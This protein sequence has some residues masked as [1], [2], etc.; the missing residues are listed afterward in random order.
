MKAMSI[1]VKTRVVALLYGLASCA[2]LAQQTP[3]QT[4]PSNTIRQ[5]AS[6]NHGRKTNRTLSPDDGLAV[7]SA[8]LDSKV[9]VFPE[10]D[11]S[12]LV[13]AIYERAGFP[14]DYVS[15]YDLY[16]GVEGF[17]RVW[18]PQP[19]DLVVW[20]GHVGIVVR[21][22]RHVFYSFLRSGPSTD[23][24]ESPYWMSRGRPRFY[25]YIKNVSCAGCAS[26]STT[27]PRIREEK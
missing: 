19:G 27:F 26:V 22:S 5:G 25:R 23:D 12:H 1:Q 7:I 11:C 24:Y 17:Q 3:G 18:Y 20:Q 16:A 4:A 6:G 8:A 2:S 14:Y 21:P 15:S 9:R 10:R 13:H